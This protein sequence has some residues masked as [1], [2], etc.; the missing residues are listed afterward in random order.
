MSVIELRK[1]DCLTVIEYPSGPNERFFANQ[2]PIQD[3]SVYQPIIFKCGKCE[4]EI[5]FQEQ[6][7]KKH[8]TSTFSNL[9]ESDTILL[10]QHK[11]EHNLEQLP[12]LDF[13]CPNCKQATQIL[14]VDG[15]GGKSD[16]LFSI[17]KVLIIE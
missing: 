3:T 12:F 5:E 7:F 11:K 8:S 9:N 2:T 6:N 14:Y 15:Y 16:Y 10:E 13:Y 1:S 17:K 4:F